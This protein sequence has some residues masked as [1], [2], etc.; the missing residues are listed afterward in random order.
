MDQVASSL[1]VAGAVSAPE[2]FRRSAA[3]QV[4]GA[5][6]AA[7][8]AVL[9]GGF[10]VA[11][12]SGALIPD[13]AM[14]LLYGGMLSFFAVLMAASAVAAFKRGRDTRVAE[15]GPGGIWTPELGH[16]PWDEIAEVRLESIGGPAG[17]RNSRIRKYR[18]LG[19]VPLDASRRPPSAA[20]LALA[21][22]KGYLG[23][24]RR[25]APDADLGDARL[26]PFGINETDVP[27]DFDRLVELAREYVVVV[28]AETRPV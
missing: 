16:V 19:L 13:L 20:G 8:G 10:A 12:L 1:A 25:L 24:V 14:R 23:L 9:F 22:T 26:A 11:M 28:D 4:G 5:F 27:K 6:G 15:L 17:P 3:A 7:I 18:R 21:M 2:V